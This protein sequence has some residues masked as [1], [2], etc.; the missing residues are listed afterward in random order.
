M[1]VVLASMTVFAS[2]SS[3]PSVADLSK[4]YNTTNNIVLACYFDEA[5]CNDI[6]FL[7]TYNNWST[8]LSQC[9]KMTAVQGYKG[10]YAVA[11]P[12][13]WY[14]NNGT[15]D[16]PSGKPIQLTS[17][18]SLDWTY[19]TGDVGA[20]INMGVSG[21]KTAWVNSGYDNEA[22]I[23][24]PEAGVYIYEIA[25]W[26]KHKSP[27]APAVK[28]DYKITLYA[29]DA[30]PDMK[31]AIIGDFNN[32]EAGIPMTEGKDANSKTVYT[33]TLKDEAEG[34]AFKIRE[35]K[36]VDWTNELQYFDSYYYEWRKFDDYELGQETNIVLD[37]SDNSRYRFAKCEPDY[38]PTYQIVVMPPK[39]DANPEFKPIIVTFGDN[40]IYNDMTRG[41]YNG[42]DAWLLTI[43]EE[44][45]RFF[46][47]A[48]SE[49]GLGN[50]IQ[51][52]DTNRKLWWGFPL[53]E[54]PWNSGTTTTLVYDYSDANRY[55]YPLCGKLN[56]DDK[57]MLNLK[58]R[59]KAPAGAPK[60]V[61]IVGDFGGLDTWGN[62]VRMTFEN[63]YYTATVKTT[64]NNQFKIREAGNSNNY[65]IYADGND[66]ENFVFG[67]FIDASGQAALIDFSD[68]TRYDWSGKGDS[69]FINVRTYYYVGGLNGWSSTDKSY[70]FKVLNDGRTW[71][72]TITAFENDGWFKI[73]PDYAYDYPSSFWDNLM[74]APYEG[75]EDLKGDMIF[76]NAGAWHMPKSDS[77]Y[78]YRIRI[79]P[80]EMTFEILPQTILL[81]SD[82][83][84]VYDA[85]GNDVTKK[86]SIVW[87]DAQKKVIGNGSIIGGLE[88]G[89]QVYYSVLL[90]KTLG[91]QYQE[92]LYK[93]AVI[94]RTVKRDTLSLIEKVK[95]HGKVSAY[96]DPI[97]RAKADIRQWLNGKYVYETY[98]LTDTKGEFA[99]EL[100]N[101]ST[102]IVLSAEGYMDRK[103]AVAHLNKD[104][105]L[106]ELEMEKVRGKVLALNITY[107]EAT[108]TGTEPLVQAWYPDT[109]NLDYTVR[110]LTTGKN[111]DNYGV[112]QGNIILPDGT[113]QGDKMQVAIRSLN[114]KFAETTG[115]GTIGTNDTAVITLNLLAF[116]ALE[117]N[118]DQKA[119][120]S[121]LVMLYDNTG[122]LQMRT[123]C[124]T[125]KLTFSNLAAGDYTL[126]TM[127]YNGAVGSLSELSELA[128]MDMRDGR[129][130]VSKKVKIR[131]GYITSVNVLSVPELDASKFEYTGSNT[132]F[133][134]NKMQLVVGNFI[135]L[136]ARVDFKAQYA[137]KVDNIKIIVD[138]PDGCEF[139]PNSV[140]IGTKALPHSLDGSKL[141]ITLSKEDIDARIRFCVIPVETGSFMTA[142][143]VEFN[144]NGIKTQPIGQIKFEATAGELF[145]PATTN[146]ATISV[147]GIGVPKAEVEVYDNENL[148]GTTKS[149]GNGKWQM[150]CE[151]SNAYNLSMH[152]I[153]VKYRGEGNIVGKTETKICYYD[154]N[155]IVPKTVTMINTAHPAGNL[156]PTVYESVFD[157][158]AILSVQNYYL[159][160]PDYPDF[161]FIIDLSDNDTAKVSD[162]ELYVY[163]TDG[164]K[165]RL[166]ATYDGNMGKFVASGS[167][168][169]YSLPTNVSVEFSTIIK[170]P[171]IDAKQITDGISELM[172]S[173]DQYQDFMNSLE[174]LFNSAMTEAD[175]LAFEQATGISFAQSELDGD[176]SMQED[177]LISSMNEEQLEAYLDSLY[178]KYVAEDDSIFNELHII[179]DNL[180][181]RTTDTIHFDGGMTYELRTCE[182]LTKEMLDSLNY[183]E[184]RMTDSSLVYF[185]STDTILSCVNFQQ[186]VCVIIH[187]PNQPGAQ[188]A[189]ARAFNSEDFWKVVDDFYK[190]YGHVTA[191]INTIYDGLKIQAGVPE[192]MIEEIE[193]RLN[194]RL[195][196]AQNYKNISKKPEKI[197]KWTA[198]EKS[199]QKALANT[200]VTKRLVGTICKRL[201]QCLPIVDYLGTL[202]SCYSSSEQIISAYRSI[203]D[204]CDNDQEKADICKAT[205]VT[206][207]LSVGAKAI[208]EVLGN[209]TA[210][211]EVVGG[212][213]ASVGTAGASLGAT[214][215]GLVQKIAVQLGGVAIDLLFD[216]GIDHVKKEIKKLQCKGPAPDGGDPGTEP[217]TPEND[218]SGYVYEAVPTNRL[219]DVTAT[220]YYRDEET[221]VQWDAE[222]FGQINPQ[223]TDASGLYAW[224]VPQGFWKVTFTKPGYE[225]TETDWLPVPPPQLEINIPMSQAV[226]PYVVSA[227]GSSSGILLEFS[228]YMKPATLTA[229]SRIFV[230]CNG[231]KIGGSVEM[232]NLEEDPY[233]QQKY[234]SKIKFV[235]NRHFQPSDNVTITVKKEV[236]SYAGM[237]M[238]EDFVQQIAIASEVNEM[239]CDSVIMVDYTDST[240]LNIAVLPAEAAK[241]IVVY[242][243]STSSMITA[244]NQT[245]VTLDNAGKARLT[246]YGKLP[247]NASLHLYIPKADVDKYVKV[248]V[249]KKESG[250][251]IKPKASKLTGSTFDNDYLLTLSCAT[252]GADIYYT[253]DGTCPCNEQTRIKYT[254]PIQLPEG[255]VTLQ[256]VA[257]REGMTDSE[258]ATYAYV[259][260]KKS[261]EGIEAVPSS[262]CEISY[263]AGGVSISGAQGATCHIYDLLG[264]ELVNQYVPTNN[265]TIRV[266]KN[267]LYIVS[268]VF[269]NKQ[270]YVCRVLAE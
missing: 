60:S 268:L 185:L 146:K 159:Y 77:I 3:V 121:L 18:G 201:L 93:K 17:D 152:E 90:D 168:D 25:Y 187:I 19:Q 24:Y 92:I 58:V 35:V 179:E 53:R 8:T 1:L 135:T 171:L 176:E 145:V 40:I 254:R 83:L 103:I 97:Q 31:P 123:V 88:E 21:T 81:E 79:V 197:A 71:E 200:R 51:W 134:P 202:R 249:L 238:T 207:E 85:K 205:C 175:I 242:V 239:V 177:S 248:N 42:S 250:I 243:E 30:C 110:N 37:H 39:C 170:E 165:R 216:Y 95:V 137:G 172:K 164:G 166:P 106:G 160:W 4:L 180:A 127:G 84:N 252:P 63:G 224:D 75:C 257:V 113:N 105:E 157:Y 267:D 192:R 266:P 67:D 191:T 144:S 50:Q 209:F 64:A 190:I 156:T 23:F 186:N 193:K 196:N 118:Y 142:A 206:L 82:V 5:V 28:H 147:G 130:Y 57:T 129:D 43:H 59:F 181:F 260:S 214:A 32:W 211:A 108:Q 69:P 232:L 162:V 198:E 223:I 20:W 36:D 173:F 141:T 111:L 115:T 246:V 7:G 107:Q 263:Q 261:P 14:Y 117:V 226:A 220:I 231:T 174:Q 72:A 12:W 89:T 143:Y 227:A 99:I 234:A 13:S 161:T 73:A 54:F 222:E 119:D 182:G 6:V 229:D 221:P 112:Q 38:R 213:I 240:V 34:H 251:V 236:E 11:V 154:I 148:I 96:G 102:E 245:S 46:Q 138:I 49:Y 262:H 139:V 131:D 265:A 264:R 270:T 100:Y 233:M 228:K 44:P 94:D 124:T 45:G 101:D 194:V 133:L 98:T 167:F 132:S 68:Y 116:G 158:E 65:L 26:K 2:P 55:R 149:L 153:Y 52:Y 183:R 256:A 56:Y 48:E 247:G 255:E 61:E 210:D 74:C 244:T 151:L 163:T 86:V 22:D 217:K 78:S 87:Y 109:R 104:G 253:L 219:E 237:Q 241:D 140:V 208:G 199:I 33:Y 41:T 225:T 62:G 184:Y 212:A 122:K 235:P 204:P 9:S 169:M 155:S 114:N 16:Y 215:W 269:A 10:W 70:P 188:I 80:A 91:T 259:V 128:E 76:G 120:A 47:I 136:S 15:S 258:I 29:P 203:P 150:N 195:I 189:A 66:T 178:E 125:S 27:C 230:T 218:P 126:V